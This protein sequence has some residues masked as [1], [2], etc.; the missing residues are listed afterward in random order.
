MSEKQPQYNISKSAAK[1]SIEVVEAIYKALFEMFNSAY[2]VSEALKNS[3][4]RHSQVK[5]FKRKQHMLEIGKINRDIH[6]VFSG[7][8]W[9]YYLKDNGTERIS[10]FLKENDMAIS[11]VSFHEQVPSYEGIYVYKD[12][13]C[14]SMSYEMLE[15]NFDNFL[16]F[17][18]I[19]RK[20]KIPY[21]VKDN[22][23]VYSFLIEDAKQKYNRLL[24]EFPDILNRVPAKIVASF[25]DIT[26]ETLSR[27]RAGKY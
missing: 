10:W 16:E 24:G 9:G 13:I 1:L 19:G 26:P 2:P 12:A 5:V 11:V 21:H 3:I 8:L 7:T 25:L 6:F 14:I 15:W 27:I 17:N 22:I 23:R 4:I 20:L 18:V